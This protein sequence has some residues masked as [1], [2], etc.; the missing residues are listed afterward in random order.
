[1]AKTP[2]EKWDEYLQWV[3]ERRADYSQPPPVAWVN[4]EKYEFNRRLAQVTKNLKIVRSRGP[5]P[6]S[7]SKS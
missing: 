6:G 7:A 1:M 5:R 3:R 2:G 4:W